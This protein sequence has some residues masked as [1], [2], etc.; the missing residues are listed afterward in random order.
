MVRLYTLC[1]SVAPF[2]L[3]LALNNGFKYRERIDNRGNGLAVL[4]YLT[5]ESSPFF[6]GRLAGLSGNWTVL[7]VGINIIFCHWS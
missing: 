6:V 7:P 3:K 1:R 4:A 2:Y 5:L